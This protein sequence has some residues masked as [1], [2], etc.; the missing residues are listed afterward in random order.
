MSKHP[1][2]EQAIACAE[3]AGNRRDTFI[4]H[5]E[6]REYVMGHYLLRKAITR[7]Q[8]SMYKARYELELSAALGEDVDDGLCPHFDKSFDYQALAG[9]VRDEAKAML[10]DANGIDHSGA[11]YEYLFDYLFDLTSI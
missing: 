7:A 6:A 5:D 1:T 10:S 3:R 11:A 2:P 8:V 9:N 4:K